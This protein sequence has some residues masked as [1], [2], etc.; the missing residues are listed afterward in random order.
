MRT[1]SPPCRARGL[2]PIEDERTSSDPVGVTVPD[3]RTPVVVG[4]LR[5]DTSESCPRF[6]YLTAPP[7][8]SGSRFD[9]QPTEVLESEAL[10]DFG[11]RGSLAG[12]EPGEPISI[13]RRSQG[14]P[15]RR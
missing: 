14:S 11:A 3:G 10:F 2:R 6:D 1:R 12:L 15:L 13:G 8:A 5:K 9:A 4:A 7:V